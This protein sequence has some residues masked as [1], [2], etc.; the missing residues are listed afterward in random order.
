MLNCTKDTILVNLTSSHDSPVY[1]EVQRLYIAVKNNPHSNSRGSKKMCKVQQNKT[2]TSCLSF[3]GLI[4]THKH[5][6]LTSSL[7]G[8][9]HHLLHLGCDVL[10]R[11][12]DKL[13]RFWG[14][15]KQ[16]KKKKNE[17]QDV[18]K[19]AKRRSETAKVQS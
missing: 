11:F 18:K 19:V 14:Q 10:L 5:T 17:R 1:I 13:R 9:V 2:P 16:T 8:N 12:L 6:Q 3:R 15:S 7:T 4:R